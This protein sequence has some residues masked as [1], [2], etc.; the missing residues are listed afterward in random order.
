MGHMKTPK[1]I[2]I[3][4]GGKWITIRQADIKTLVTVGNEEDPD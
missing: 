4:K 2:R 3:F 1:S